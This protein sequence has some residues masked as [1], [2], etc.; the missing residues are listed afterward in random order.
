MEK[1][2]KYRPIRVS[3][4]LDGEQLVGYHDEGTETTLF[5]VTEDMTND[6]VVII[7]NPDEGMFTGLKYKN[8][9]DA[10]SAFKGAKDGKNSN[11]ITRIL[12]WLF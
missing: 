12:E 6:Y 1:E 3:Q 9:D 10:R 8:L 5:K 4:H 7:E 2:E 11:I